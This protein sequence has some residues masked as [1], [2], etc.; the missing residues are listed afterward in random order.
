MTEEAGVTE[1]WG[2][3]TI[4]VRAVI[5]F[6]NEGNYLIHG[7]NDESFQDMA[8]AIAPIWVFDP[9]NEMIQHIEFEM[10]V[11]DLDIVNRPRIKNAI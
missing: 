10:E 5:A 6:D 8:K 7:S 11:P 2:Y 1:E 3:K 4:K 9:A